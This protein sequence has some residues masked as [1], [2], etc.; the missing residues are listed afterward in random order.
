MKKEGK[1]KGFLSRHQVLA[2]IGASLLLGILFIVVMMI[3]TGDLYTG[4]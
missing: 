1:W 2:S 4:V 3:F